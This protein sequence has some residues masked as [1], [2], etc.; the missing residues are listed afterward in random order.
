MKR[1]LNTLLPLAALLALAFGAASCGGGKQSVPAAEHSSEANL[2]KEARLLRIFNRDSLGFV[3][4]EVV[5][6]WDTTRLLG[7]YAL[8]EGERPT[9]IP[10]GYTPLQVPLTRTLVYSGV[11]TGLLDELGRLDAVAGV[12]DGEYFTQQPMASWVRS[13]KV[14]NV[15]PSASPSLEAIVALKPQAVFLSPFENAG[16]GVVGEA[17]VPLIQCADYMEATPKGRAEWVKLFG[18]L[19]GA[20][21]K[22]DSIY[23]AVSGE[24]DR[25]TSMASKSEHKP[26]VLTEMLTDGYWFVPGG[27]SYAARLLQ[28]AGAAYPWA[29]NASSG[30]L[31]LDFSSVYARAA[32]ADVWLVR[33]YGRDLTLADLR[34]NYTL[35]GQFKAFKEGNVWC[36]NTSVVPL[37]EEFPFH[38][39]RLLREYVAIFHPELLPNEPLR[40]F[41]KMK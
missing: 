35:N 7:S 10:S 37:F 19:F 15:G 41:K 20:S 22:A 28:D 24:Y 29:A 25:L 2:V 14:V 40:Y 1:L 27:K 18:L 31:Q 30:S 9:S 8:Y 21:D 23:S 17:G 38:P 33:S 6:P 36:A 32:D 16:T 11:H 5:N 34:S 13:G 3:A 39:E 12:A 26:L 4:V